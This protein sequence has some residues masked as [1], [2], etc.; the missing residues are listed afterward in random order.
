MNNIE[1]PKSCQTAKAPISLP[2]VDGPE[3]KLRHQ[4]DAFGDRGFGSE[5]PQIGEHTTALVLK[6]SFNVAPCTTLLFLAVLLISMPVSPL[7]ILRAGHGQTTF[8]PFCDQ[9]CTISGLVRS[10]LQPYEDA[11][12]RQLAE[13]RSLRRKPI[14]RCRIARE[15]LSSRLGIVL[16]VS[17]RAMEREHITM[18]GVGCLAVVAALH[19]QQI[20]CRMPRVFV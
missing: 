13:L 2:G 16:N 17:H 14:A 6:I 20:R 11:D 3:A 8:K 19:Y 5:P 12:H 1:L 10:P 4:G 15:R 9:S 18:H 7:F